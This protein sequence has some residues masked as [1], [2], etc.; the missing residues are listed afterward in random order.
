MIEKLFLVGLGY[1][2]CLATIYVA[3]L[4]ERLSHHYAEPPDEDAAEALNI[5]S[6]RARRTHHTPEHGRGA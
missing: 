4:L 5:A 3:Y 1:L 6:Y 2:L